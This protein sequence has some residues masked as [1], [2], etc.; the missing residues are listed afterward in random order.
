MRFI[1]EILRRKAPHE[2]LLRRRG[3]GGFVLTGFPYFSRHEIAELPAFLIPEANESSLLS[4]CRPG[5]K[6]REIYLPRANERFLLSDADYCRPQRPPILTVSLVA[7]RFGT[8][9]IGFRNSVPFL[10]STRSQNS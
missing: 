3:A 8:C 9:S 2:P 10:V 5:L 6:N 4:K 1:L 7:E